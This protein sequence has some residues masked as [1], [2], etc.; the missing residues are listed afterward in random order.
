MIQK[1]ALIC[2]GGWEG[3]TPERSAIIAK[4]ML[5]QNGFVVSLEKGTAP[6]AD[7]ALHKLNL[8]VPMI[9]MTKPNTSS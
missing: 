1:Q 9:T 3:H 4:Q 5:E 7:P 2:W 6:F 8:V